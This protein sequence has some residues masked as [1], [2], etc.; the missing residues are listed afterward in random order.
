MRVG[1]ALR[2]ATATLGEAGIEAAAREARLLMVRAL[3][4]PDRAIPDRDA[5]APDAF[6]PLLERRRVREPM[7]LI[8][9]RQGFWT[10][11]VAVSRD[12]LI[13]RADSEAVLRAALRAR[14]DRA[15]VRRVL[16]LGT[17]TGALLLAA[18]AEF[19]EAFGLGIDLSAAACALAARNAVA[20]RLAP[21]AAFLCGD[22]ARA[23]AARFDLVLANPPYIETGAIDALMPEVASHEPRRAL[24]GGADGLAA[25]RVI[26]GDLPRLLAPAAVVVLELGQGQ[27]PAVTALAAAAGLATVDHERDL[28]GIVRALAMQM[29]GEKKHLA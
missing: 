28:G 17:G 13:P 22:W 27:A 19:P 15:G 1:T 26:L 12:T 16:D 4:L 2:Q 7:A 8:L 10:L 6:W 5:P 9:G 14:P 11:D 18:L 25:Y 20:N 3:G 24:D 29:P 21:R 23:V